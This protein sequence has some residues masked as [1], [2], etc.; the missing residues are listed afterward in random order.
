MFDMGIPFEGYR[1]PHPVPP[2]HSY[3]THHRGL[4]VW[5]AQDNS[6]RVVD[7]M[8]TV[9]RGELC[10]HA[11]PSSVPSDEDVGG[12]FVGLEPRRF[13]TRT[14]SRANARVRPLY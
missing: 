12:P 13:V 7:D 14:G 2:T 10:Q 6:R 9:S 1:R 11:D 5:T 3:L 8:S 4:G